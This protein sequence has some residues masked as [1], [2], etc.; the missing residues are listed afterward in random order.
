MKMKRQMSLWILSTMLALTTV[1]FGCS[2]NNPLGPDYKNLPPSPMS[3]ASSKS[4]ADGNSE[5]PA[6]TDLQITSVTY[7]GDRVYQLL[8][9]LGGTLNI[10]LADYYSYFYVPPAALV[11]SL[12]LSVQATEG[13]NRKGEKITDYDFWPDGLIFEKSAYLEYRT[14][15]VDGTPVQLWWFN[16]EKNAWEMVGAGKIRNHK[17]TFPIDHFSNYR[18]W[19]GSV[20]ASGQ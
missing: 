8:G 13:Y 2:K 6:Q 5:E 10:P 11:T 17:C 19:E 7:E 18:T 3:A 20:S 1:W 9:F 15:G 4:S 12:V 14:P 16:P